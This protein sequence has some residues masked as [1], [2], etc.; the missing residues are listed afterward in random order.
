MLRHLT[1]TTLIALTAGALPAAAHSLADS[2][3]APDGETGQY[4]VFEDDGS[5]QGNAGCNRFFG[6]FT[7][8]GHQISMGPFGTTRKFCGKTVMKA[9][10]N[11]LATLSSAKRFEF[12]HSLL[13]LF[14]SRGE[15]LLRLKPR[16]WD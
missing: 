16:D 14:G 8:T 7:T 15:V 13:T 6:K 4:I 11:F 2:E 5:V 1:A 10:R 9:E 3:W 12:D